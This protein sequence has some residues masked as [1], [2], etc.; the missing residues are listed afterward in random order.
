MEGYEGMK[1]RAAKIPPASR[2]RLTEAL[3]RIVELYE[4]TDRPEQ[5]EKWRKEL[6]ASRAKDKIN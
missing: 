2:V 1:Q 4:S 3:Q 6:E 5:A